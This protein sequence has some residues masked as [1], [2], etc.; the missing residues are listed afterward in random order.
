MTPQKILL[1]DDD[2]VVRTLI[3]GILRKK[4]YEVLLA[5]NGDEG[6]ALVSGEQPDLVITDYQ[7]PGM[8]GMEVLDKLRAEDPA[9]PVV[10]LTA[11]GDAG[12][13]IKSIQTG[14]FDFI[15]KPI[16]PRELLDIVRNGLSTA[17]T[18]AEEDKVQVDEGVQQ[19]DE[20]LMVGKSPAMREIFKN[21][22]RISQNN[23]HVI[24]T[25]ETGSGKERLARLIHTSGSNR[26]GRLVML[27]CKK[28]AEA[29]LREAY[30]NNFRSG[31]DTVSGNASIVLDEVGSLSQELQVSL[32]DLIDHHHGEQ[33]STPPRLI[34]LTTTD[35]SHLVQDG[36]FL[37]ELFYKM[38]I[39]SI[40]IPPLR[41]RK[42]DIPELVQHLMEEL[43]PHLNKKLSKIEDGVVQALKKYSWP[44]NVQELKN[45]V[46]QAMIFS[47][48][49][50]LEKKHIQVEGPQQEME[51]GS[52]LDSPPRSL[53]EV[54]KEHIDLVLTYT[55]WNKQ[56]SA[57]IL[58]ITRPTLNAKIEKYGLRRH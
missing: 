1:I 34:A 14:A 56:E 57:A 10:M 47:H 25:G 55:G 38:K 32:L 45:V 27:N 6:L 3:S 26:P 22:G 54:E 2:P 4:G 35:I 7:M 29:G 53:A 50:V 8:S 33:S 21:I 16:N 49:E 48:G 5:K 28:V 43:N 17:Q 24:I 19:R 52:L 40:Y 58:G 12:L 18:A 51:K 44:G 20:N 46:M 37:R 41:Q 23:V 30:M 15:E 36:K 13:T 39:F 42:D 31:T 9:L 11:H